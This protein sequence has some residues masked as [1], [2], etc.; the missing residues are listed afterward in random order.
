[1]KYRKL[2]IG[3][4]LWKRAIIARRQY[5]RALKKFRQLETS[6]KETLNKIN[7]KH[8]YELA[9]ERLKFQKLHTEWS[10]RFLQMLGRASL[11]NALV[12]VEE[13]VANLK[14]HDPDFVPKPD[15]LLSSDQKDYLDEIKQKFIQDG[16]SQGKSV[17]QIND[18]WDIMKPKILDDIQN[19]VN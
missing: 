1:M 2:F 12:S 9:V 8:E 11:N 13:D 4:R 16:E 18:F 7:K 19:Q 10:N 5:K 17:S 15:E 14:N 3:M 6:S